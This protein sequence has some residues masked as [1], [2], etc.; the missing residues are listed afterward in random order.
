[1][2]LNWASLHCHSSYSLLDGFGDPVKIAERCKE[3]GY[4]AAA[5]T[6]HGSIAG[7]VK[8]FKACKSIDIKPILGCEFYVCSGDATEKSKEN[9]SLTHAVILSKNLNGWNE[10]IQAISDSYSPEHFYFKP[11]MDHAMMKKHLGNGNHICIVGHPGTELSNCLF[12]SNQAYD[13]STVAEAEAML[14]PDWEAKAREVINKYL[15]IFGENLYIE[16][17][18]IDEVNLPAARVIADKLRYL[19]KDM[20]LKP[21]ATGDSHYV[22]KSDAVYQRILLCSN[23]GRTLG[24]V[25][26]DLQMGKPVPLGTFF[27]S[28]N[29]HIPSLEELT[30][31]HTE[32]EITNAYKIG[33][34]CEEYDILNKPMLPDFKCPNNQDQFEYLTELCRQGWKKLLI[35]SGKL[36]GDGADKYLNRIT[37]EL[38]V[39]KDAGLSG[40]FLIVQDIIQY[41]RSRGWLPGVGRGSAAGCL[42]SFLIG[43]TGI[44]PIPFNLL[45]SRFFNAGR[46]GTLPDIDMDVPAKH[47]DEVIA[48]IKE[49][50]GIENVSQ[51]ATFNS[52]AGRSA[53]K[54]VLRI[55]SDVSFAEMN[56][57]TE[58]I[59]DE[60]AI[61]DEL[62]ATGETSIIRWALTNRANR[63]SKWVTLN[64]DGTLTGE[65]ADYF[66]KAIAIEGTPKSQGKHAAG[67]I[68][69]AK[70]LRD[71]C[72]MVRDKEGNPIAGFE[73]GDLEALGHVK[74]DVL[75]IRLLDKIMAISSHGGIDIDNFEDE[76]VW[77][78]LS[79]GDTKGVFQLERQS[80]WTKLLKP[81]NIHHLSA[82]V[83]IIR[84]GV[85]EAM[86]D[87]KSMTRHYIDRK[88]GLE[89]VT[90]LHPALEP[91]LKDTYGIIIYQ[92]SA[93]LIA[94]K[95]AG[96]TLDEADTLRKAIGKKN[97][98]L[99]AKVKT[100]FLEGA[101]RVGVLSDEEAAQIFEW[102]EKSQRYSFNASHSYA[103]AINAYYSAICK[104]RNRNKF[105][106]EYLN[107]AQHEQKSQEEIRELVNDAKLYNIEILPP[108]LDNFYRDFT[109]ATDGSYFGDNIYFGVGHIKDVGTKDCEKLFCT[110]RDFSKMTWM[111]ILFEFGGKGINQKAFRA[112]VQ[113]GAFNGKSNKTSRNQ[114]LYEYN[115]WRGLTAREINYIKDH[116][117]PGE[118]LEYHVNDLVN[119]FKIATNRLQ[120]VL[121]VL[122]LLKN[123]PYELT[124]DPF[125]IATI[126]KFYF[127]IGLTCGQTDY[128][129][130]DCVDSNCKDVRLGAVTGRVNLAV[131]LSAIREHKIKAGKKSAGKLM[132]FLTIEDSSAEMNS[133]VIFPDEYEKQKHVLFEGNTILIQGKAERK[134]GEVS[135]IV[136]KVYQI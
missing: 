99:M 93:M 105:Y 32:E 31:I 40:Y 104:K 77:E 18:L 76:G 102:I 79:S 35:P 66:E 57:M 97:T 86:L 123:P 128:I 89:P 71:V 23:L 116:Y 62:E 112:L 55:C 26:K 127:G 83:A 43:I 111:D 36:K 70:P 49:K 106:E 34:M 25:S 115:A 11:R 9:K 78:M 130:V 6:D 45:F 117:T 96:F 121:G 50:Y 134:D 73:M 59:P 114:M 44:D 107:Q 119:N 38:Q 30:P 22:Y 7:C 4:E 131:T 110:P 136:D 51:M 39:I 16:I 74:F 28:D 94:S 33:Q 132:A 3:L 19:A 14:A 52:L 53:L 92:E 61:A 65:M 101:K 90:Y 41:C 27:I 126:E 88:N 48:Y 2:S 5:L 21:V 20:G 98:E 85:C 81:E 108:R 135:L 129:N 87:G 47:R 75:G 67:I 42:V 10:L 12:T 133:V 56:D 69:S 15:D 68:I 80:R 91:I 113:S 60:A 118:S 103:Y 120:S 24:G 72:P 125:W 17:Q 124:D 1:M 58:A 46:I 100:Q 95:L 37:E 122:Q 13:C 64:E 29:Y 109:M 82:L 54:E 63:F 8:F 84:P